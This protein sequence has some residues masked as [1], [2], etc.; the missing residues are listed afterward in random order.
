MGGMSYEEGKARLKRMREFHEKGAIKD[1]GRAKNLTQ[2]FINSV[3]IREGE[4]AVK[5]LMR[6]V[7][8]R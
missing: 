2:S 1:H 4:R 3:R 6:E 7:N 8:S 5:E